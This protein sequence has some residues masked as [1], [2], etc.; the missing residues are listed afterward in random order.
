MLFRSISQLEENKEEFALNADSPE[1]QQLLASLDTI[2]RRELVR[3]SNMIH[4]KASRGLRDFASAF[5][6]KKE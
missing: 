5:R 4:S 3:V 2:Y 1:Q 6:F